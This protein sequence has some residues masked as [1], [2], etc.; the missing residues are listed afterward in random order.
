MDL[1]TLA[2]IELAWGYILLGAESFILWLKH[3][4]TRFAYRL[5]LGMSTYWGGRI[6][7]RITD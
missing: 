6:P 3:G 7:E 1:S 5:D 4:Q 2:D